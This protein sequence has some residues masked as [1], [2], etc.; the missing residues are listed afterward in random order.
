[1]RNRDPESPYP[2]TSSAQQTLLWFISSA[3]NPFSVHTESFSISQVRFIRAAGTSAIN[4]TFHTQCFTTG[5][6]NYSC[7]EGLYSTG[8]LLSVTLLRVFQCPSASLAMFLLHLTVLLAKN[9]Q[10]RGKHPSAA[11][12]NRDQAKFCWQKLHCCSHKH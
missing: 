2:L 6:P 10:T 1:M 4:K 11:I 3:F 12:T 5:Y 8:R 9:T 7:S